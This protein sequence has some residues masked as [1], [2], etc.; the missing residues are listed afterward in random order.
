MNDP[1]LVWPWYSLTVPS[2]GKERT[3]WLC[4]CS[5]LPFL[6]LYRCIS[7][8]PNFHVTQMSHPLVRMPFL[9]HQLRNSLFP[10]SSQRVHLHSCKALISR[11]NDGYWCVCLTSVC[12]PVPRAHSSLLH[13]VLKISRPSKDSRPPCPFVQDCLSD[14]GT[15]QV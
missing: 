5:P 2:S 3:L 13:S 14:F 9:I 10:L 15:K 7:N 1:K 4:S 11:P 6:H 8:L 12:P